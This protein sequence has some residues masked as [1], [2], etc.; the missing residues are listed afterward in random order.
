MTN[1]ISKPLPDILAP[2]LKIL[3][4]GYNPGLR[5][6]EMGHH[7]AG[8]SNRFWDILY[9][10]GLTA[11][12]LDYTR[13]REL[14]SYGY[15]STN[16]IDRP[17]KS[18][19]ELARKEYLEGKK[20]LRELLNEYKPSVACYVGIGVYKSFSG[21][22]KVEWGQQTDQILEGILDFVAPST[23]GL[24]RMPIVAQVKIYSELKSL[25]DEIEI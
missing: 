19:N 1:V 24:N 23:S 20:A 14:L 25:I 18:A 16:I 5:S 12:K 17:S 3:F 2:G 10:A 4:I 7:Y 22:R 21:K 13:D 6:A 15:G 11:E 9:R 8:K